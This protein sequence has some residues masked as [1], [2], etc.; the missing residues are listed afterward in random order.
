[1]ATLQAHVFKD[2]AASFT[3]ALSGGGIQFSRRVQLSEAPMAAGT[4]IEIFSAIKDANPWGALAAVVVAWL[5]AKATRKVIITTKDNQI[6]HAEGLSASEVE[7]I[8]EKAKDVGII[9][10]PSKDKP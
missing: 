1:M 5:A 10:R 3:E 9:D 2:S 6:I 7:R 8:L 4:I